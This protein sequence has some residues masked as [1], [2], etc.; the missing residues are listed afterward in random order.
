MQW[1]FFIRFFL[2]LQAV[3]NQFSKAV[4]SCDSSPRAMVMVSIILHHLQFC[5]PCQQREW[6]MWGEQC[7]W[8]SCAGSWLSVLDLAH[9]ITQHWNTPLIVH[10]RWAVTHP[11]INR[12]GEQV[13]DRQQ[14]NPEKSEHYPRVHAALQWASRSVS[15]ITF[16]WMPGCEKSDLFPLS[17][18]WVP[19]QCE[20]GSGW[21]CKY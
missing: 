2:K 21:S 9:W 19:I 16:I 4:R 10:R 12:S 8:Q 14:T 5:Y 20:S 11:A 1:K 7:Y 6:G 13:W 15:T 18:E 17:S 3:R